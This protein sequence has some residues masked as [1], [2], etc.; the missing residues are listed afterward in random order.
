MRD[1]IR[2]S[3][4]PALVH[5][6]LS[7]LFL[8]GATS[9]AHAFPWS[10]WALA[11]SQDGKRVYATDPWG[12]GV[13]VIDTA[14]NQLVRVLHVGGT[15]LAA[16]PDGALLYGI[17][18]SGLSISSLIT[19]EPVATVKIGPGL[20]GIV[21]SPNGRRVYVAN[22]LAP[23]RVWVIDPAAGAVVAAL[24]VGP[25]PSGMALQ[26]DGQR[27]YVAS[28]GAGP[29]SGA[30]LTG[31]VTVID[32][33]TNEVIVTVSVHPSSSGVV[34]SPDGR[35]VYVGEDV[36]DTTVLGRDT[37]APGAPLSSAGAI[38]PDG[39][40]IYALS[41]EFSIVAAFDLGGL[42]ASAVSPL[43]RSPIALA[44]SPDGRRVYVENLSG[45]LSVLAADTLQP[46]A[47][48]DLP[49]GPGG[50]N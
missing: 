19:G 6:L 21:V 5:F 18:G 29:A 42:Q 24:E 2:L 34:A 46:V 26:P 23:G 28:P 9:A 30:G 1:R 45:S 13:A 43:E 37:N 3:A 33:A 47:T 14:T 50:Q 41:R 40:R 22:D 11:V 7:F 31:K 4:A 44:L 17:N 25:W 20:A 38:S 39:R 27:L 32:T 35:R 8:G 15:S 10:P 16:S 12:P 49:R 36:I 48:I